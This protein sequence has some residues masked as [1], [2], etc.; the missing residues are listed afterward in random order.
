MAS[1]YM[2]KGQ[3]H[4]FELKATLCEYTNHRRPV[5][6]D[7]IVSSAG[8]TIYTACTSLNSVIILNH[9]PHLFIFM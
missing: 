6:E 1:V 8:D 9:D 4:I 3:G 5:F 2:L 7:C